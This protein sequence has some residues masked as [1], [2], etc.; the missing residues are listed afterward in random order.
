MRPREQLGEISGAGE[1]EIR[2]CARAERLDVQSHRS[3]RRLADHGRPLGERIVEMENSNPL[4][5]DLE[6]VEIA[7]SIKR[8]ANVVAR[9]HHVD[10]RRLELMQGSHAAPA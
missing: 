5:P 9:Y 8:V 10:A 4:A 6:H 1:N 7:V 2:A 3:R